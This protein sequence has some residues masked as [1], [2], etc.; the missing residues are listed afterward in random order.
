MGSFSNTW[1]SQCAQFLGTVSE[2]GISYVFPGKKGNKPPEAEKMTDV[3]NRRTGP[4]RV[5]FPK[6]E[7]GLGKIFEVS[8]WQK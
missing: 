2:K 7:N 1:G 5:N 3:L 8:Y 4:P 6:T